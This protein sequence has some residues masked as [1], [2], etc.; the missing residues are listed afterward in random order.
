MIKDAAPKELYLIFAFGLQRYR[1]NGAEQK[2]RSLLRRFHHNG[3]SCLR[4]ARPESSEGAAK[5]LKN[6]KQ[7]IG[8]INYSA[9]DRF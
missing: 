8:K 5:P 3:I 7:T 9:G 2:N 1:P 4:T 6:Q